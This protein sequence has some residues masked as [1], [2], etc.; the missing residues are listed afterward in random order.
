MLSLGMLSWRAHETLRKTLSSYVHLVPLVDEAVIYFNAITDED[1][2]IASE[3]GFRAEGTHENLGILGGTLA[4]ARNLHG[5][6]VILVQN[7]NPVNVPQDMLAR[8]LAAAHSLLDGGMADMVRLRDRFDH[9]FSDEDKY[10]RYW[11]GEGCRDTL[12]LRLRRMMRPAKAKRMAARAPSVLKDP[13]TT[14]PDIFKRVG[15]AFIGD[16]S[17]IDYSDQPFLTSRQLISE[18][19]EWADRNK[20]NTSTLNGMPVPEI[21]INKH[22]WRNRHLRIA[23]TDGIFSHSRYDGSF[24]KD[25]PSYDMP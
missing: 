5:D 13:S 20:A 12:C 24:R 14:H 2:K 10:M 18:L 17:L 1:R 21:V 8:R 9:S 15:D 23:V 25:H 7:D 3:F 22:G 4:L 11:P 19:L 16:S 6:K